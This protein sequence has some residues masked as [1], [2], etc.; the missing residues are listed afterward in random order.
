MQV[1]EKLVLVLQNYPLFRDRFHKF[2]KF[3]NSEAL[4]MW[5]IR[6]IFTRSI[7]ESLN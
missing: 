6:K 5:R 2:I 4:I 1:V 3:A 7:I